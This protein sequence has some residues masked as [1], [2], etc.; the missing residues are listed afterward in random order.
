MLVVITDG[1]WHIGVGENGKRTIWLGSDSG[2]LYVLI[3]SESLICCGIALQQLSTRVLVEQAFAE[4]AI[5][6]P[7]ISSILRKGF[8]IKQVKNLVDRHTMNCLFL[9]ASGKSP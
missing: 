3:V 5:L 4:S 9:K 6:L 1:Q 8:S 2:A 7:F